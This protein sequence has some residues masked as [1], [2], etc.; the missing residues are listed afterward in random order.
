VVLDA[1]FLETLHKPRDVRLRPPE[2]RG[3]R[4]SL[5]Q[6]DDDRLVGRA[7]GRCRGLLHGGSVVYSE[8]A[9]QSQGPLVNL[10]VLLADDPLHV[11]KRM[12]NVRIERQLL[13]EALLLLDAQLYIAGRAFEED[14]DGRKGSQEG[15]GPQVLRPQDR[16]V[17]NRP[18]E[19]S[20]CLVRRVTWV[21]RAVPL[22]GVV[23][24]RQ[25]RP[26]VV[27]GELVLGLVVAGRRAAVRVVVVRRGYPLLLGRET[28]PRKFRHTILI[29]HA[30]LPVI[31]VEL[32]GKSEGHEVFTGSRPWRC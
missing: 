2:L 25:L 28:C 7:D 24:L 11:T 15:L 20:R 8:S 18:E 4:I 22:G 21:V 16:A 17:L 31:L 3:R 23:P 26:A 9:G 13:S 5:P 19:L 29:S 27:V 30:D 1:S 14:L 32:P 6:G 12:L 10:V